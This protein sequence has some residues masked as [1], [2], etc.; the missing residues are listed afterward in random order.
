MCVC[1]NRLNSSFTWGF[2]WLNS[3]GK[4][5]P[6]LQWG[7]DPVCCMNWCQQSGLLCQCS[8]SFAFSIPTHTSLSLL[9]VTL[10]LITQHGWISLVR[11]TGLLSAA[12]DEWPACHKVSNNPCCLQNDYRLMCLKREFIGFVH[13]QVDCLVSRRDDR[14]TRNSPDSKSLT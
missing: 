7:S 5:S 11:N 14:C 3:C 13:T 2:C 8:W 9:K 4:S 6:N 1:N 12:N 10:H